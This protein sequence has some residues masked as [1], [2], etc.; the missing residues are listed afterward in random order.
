M[1]SL[2]ILKIYSEICLNC[3]MSENYFKIFQKKKWEQLK[4]HLQNVD[5]LKLGCGFM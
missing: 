4:Q 3:I 5:N 1:L 2:Y